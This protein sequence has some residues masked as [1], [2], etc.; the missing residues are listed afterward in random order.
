MLLAYAQTQPTPNAVEKLN[1]SE[2]RRARMVPD[3]Q[4]AAA[5]SPVVHVVSREDER[6]F[7]SSIK[8]KYIRL[9]C[10]YLISNGLYVVAISV[11]LAM[12][13]NVSMSHVYD[14]L[15]LCNYHL[16]Y[17]VLSVVVCVSVMSILATVYFMSKPRRVYLVDF[18]CYKP[19]D[20][21]F[22]CTKE[23]VLELISGVVN[24]ES[25]AFIKKVLERSGVGDKCYAAGIKDFPPKRPFDCARNEAETVIIG[26]IDDLFAK[27]RVNPKEIGILIVNISAFNP[28]PSLSAMIVN[29]YKLRGDVV[30]CNLGGMGCSAGLI[31]I[32]LAK[33]LLQ[34]QRN[35]YALVMSLESMTHNYYAGKNRSKLLSNCLFRMGGAAILLSNRFSDRRRS[36]YEL[37][38]TLRT[39]RG[40]DDRSYKCVIQE[41]D[42]EGYLGMSLSKDLMNVA[43][44][45]LQAHITTLGPLVL[46]MSEQLLFLATLLARKVFKMKIKP[47]VP[48]FKLAFENFCIHTGGR[49]VL[50]ELEKNLNLTGHDIEPSRMTL[51][52]F[53]NTSSSSIWYELAYS[54]AKGR[55]KKGNR[56]WQIAFGSGFK[57]NSGVWRALKTIDPTKE[58]N[59][60]TD[61]INQFPVHIP[62]TMPI[63]S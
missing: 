29:R 33:R 31:A 26:A 36:K 50:D 19:D 23:M 34:G 4:T 10:R 20:P 40:A 3:G 58:K 30:S 63:G 13:A 41:E 39:H 53:G 7:R 9:G 55:V 5:S 2:E 57:C 46:P 54:E 32:D 12:A 35:T 16:R 37:I 28:T 8:L 61:E 59:V 56:V 1:F 48:D 15:Q 43:G 38:H 45:A 17:N 51:Y 24:E 47:H 11:A 14:I 18:S 60:W 25:S 22:M 62:K 27:T 52:R 49:A 42:D 21:S 44:E 6:N